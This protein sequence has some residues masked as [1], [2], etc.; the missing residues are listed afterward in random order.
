[1]NIRKIE[2][3]LFRFTVLTIVVKDTNTRPDLVKVDTRGWRGNVEPFEVKEFHQA[4][5]SASRVP[6]SDWSK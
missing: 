4:V 1:M 3:R 6:R 5:D 2:I